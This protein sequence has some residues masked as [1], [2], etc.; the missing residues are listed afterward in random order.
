MRVKALKDGDSIPERMLAAYLTDPMQIELRQIPVPQIRDDEVLIRVESVGVCGSDV[1][2]YEHGRIGRYVVERPLILGHECAGTVVRVGDGVHHLRVGD[3][4]AV[5]PGVTCG[6]CPACKSGRYNLCPDVQFLATPPVDGAFAQYLAHRADFV[7]RIPDDMSFEQAALVEPFSV[8]LHA[9]N[10]VRLQAG[11][12]VAIMGMGPVGLM[13]VIAAK[14][15]GASEIVVGDVEPRRLDVALQMGATHAIHVGTQ[16]VGEVV[17]D[18]FGGEGVDVGIETA[19]NP[20]ALTSLFAMVRRGGRM[21]LVGMP[22]IAENTINV[23][24]F[25]DDEIEMCGVFR[26]ANTYPAGISLLR[27]IDTSSLITD[28]YPLSRVGEALE[29]ARTNKAGSIKVM[30]YPQR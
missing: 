16:A 24:Q 13:C 18:L 28:A 1:H 3:R 22:P 12:R 11:E 27:R 8:G 23:T 17:Q 30:V 29:R 21:G 26:Y 10:R 2:Y 5:E 15:K 4:V 9:L 19:G 6:R 7:Y 20:A 25:V 14:M